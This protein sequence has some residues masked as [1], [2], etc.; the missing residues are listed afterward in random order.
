MN[1]ACFRKIQTLRL[2]PKAPT[3]KSVSTLLEELTGQGFVIDRRSLQRDLKSLANLFP[4]E[5]DGN[6]DIPGWY[7]RKDAQK[8]ELPEMEPTV[9]L[10]FQMVKTHLKKFMP[11]SVLSELSPYFSNADK[12]LGN[13]K[14]NELSTWSDKVATINR[15]QPL[16]APKID[17]EILSVIY[18]ALLSET[19]IKAHYQ[20]KLEEPRDYT[21]NPFGIVIVDQ[22]IYLVGTLWKY[23]GVR[24]F[25]LHRFLKAENT[26]TS[27]IETN[28]FSLKDYIDGGQFY[29]P[30]EDSNKKMVLKIRTNK[31]IANH[32][33]ESKLSENQSVLK[34]D[35]ETYEITATVDN[36]QQLRWW[37]NGFGAGIEVLEPL[38][39]RQEFIDTS[40]SLSK[41]YSSS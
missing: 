22:V 25:A 35:D 23:K 18:L 36:T 13:L 3:R 8:L 33:E 15:S 30:I 27:N 34:L 39:L 14:Q 10:S 40:Q 7:W 31:W 37:L 24:Q 12:L 2:L 38:F 32:L 19:Q 11:P 29:F 26:Q 17:N 4:I 21:I 5:N 16:I 6:K 20:P 41:L 28:N 1:D 9:A